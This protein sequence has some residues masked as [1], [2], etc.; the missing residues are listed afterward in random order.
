[1]NNIMKR[2]T[3]CLNALTVEAFIIGL[4]A[5]QSTPGLRAPFL[6]HDCTPG[7]APAV[8][9]LRYKAELF[10]AICQRVGLARW[11]LEAGESVATHENGQ[12]R[13]ATDIMRDVNCA[14]EAAVRRDPA[15]W[16]WVPRRWK[17]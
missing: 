3:E 10:T 5:D 6:G 11:R 9:A 14:L 2:H 1:M 15:N 17:D 13:P 16:F 8:L 7:L 12:P 4:L